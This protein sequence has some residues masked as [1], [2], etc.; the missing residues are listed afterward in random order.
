M[1]I[2][3]LLLSI[4]VTI[5]LGLI[6]LKVSNGDFTPL[7]WI[8]G[9]VLLAFLTFEN[10]R[11][12]NAIDGHRQIEDI[13]T[14]VESCLASTLP[15]YDNS[16]LFTMEEA[17]YIA[18]TIKASDPGIARYVHASDFQGK[19]WTS[20]TDTLHSIIKKSTGRYIGYRIGWC[21][22]AIIIASAL[23]LLLGVTRSST[24][25]SRS[26]HQD[27]GYDD[28]LSGYNYDSE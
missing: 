4:V 15:D 26:S 3:G 11:L 19:T 8:V 5:I 10:T 20:I 21:L 14:S 12:L 9:I 28:D 27:Y 18:L 1:L 24:S 22:L 6:L 16:H 13:V 7:A 23:V 25:R 2:W 17:Q